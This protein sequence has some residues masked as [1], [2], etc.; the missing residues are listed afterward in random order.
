MQTV[1][2]KLFE[3]LGNVYLVT[4]LIICGVTKSNYGLC[5]I[6]DNQHIVKPPNAT[7][8]VNGQFFNLRLLPCF[9]IVFFFCNSITSQ[10][11]TSTFDFYLITRL[12]LAYRIST[13]GIC[14]S[15]VNFTNVCVNLIDSLSSEY[16]QISVVQRCS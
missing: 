15:L 8:S 11:R 10:L 2:M 12:F 7:T 5:N 16:L 3:Y 9:R 6:I 14:V 4:K 1:A 13:R